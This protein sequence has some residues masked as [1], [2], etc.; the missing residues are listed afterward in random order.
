MGSPFIF[1][2][3]RCSEA[4]SGTQRALAPYEVLFA[5]W[6][7]SKHLAGYAQRDA[8]EFLISLLDGMHSD[9]PEVRSFFLSSLGK[10]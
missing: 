2:N 9:S 3:R 5:V 7:H 1:L 6:Q 4:F 8:H 10:A